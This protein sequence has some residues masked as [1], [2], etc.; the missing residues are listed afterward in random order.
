MATAELFAKKTI[1]Q[2]CDRADTKPLAMEAKGFR[3]GD[4]FF[5]QGFT[6]SFR[7]PFG[8]HF[9]CVFYGVNQSIGFRFRDRRKRYE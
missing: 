8:Y 7:N 4:A 1:W 5:F 2:A 3:D 9:F 6:F